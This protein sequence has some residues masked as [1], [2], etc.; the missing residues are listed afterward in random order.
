MITTCNMAYKILSSAFYLLGRVFSLH[1][2][3]SN[4]SR[5]RRELKMSGRPAE[6]SFL[7]MSNTFR[8]LNWL[9]L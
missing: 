4:F 9:M 8:L 3:N 6:K 1:K 2:L 7:L 5:E